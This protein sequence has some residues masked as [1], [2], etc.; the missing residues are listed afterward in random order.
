MFAKITKLILLLLFAGFSG[1][2]SKRCAFACVGFE[3]F[4]GWPEG[5]FTFFEVRR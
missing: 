2:A 1:F 5:A 4:G 3:G